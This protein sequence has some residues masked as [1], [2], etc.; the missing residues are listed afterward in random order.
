MARRWASG[1]E[2]GADE[3]AEDLAAFGAPPEIRDRC[4]ASEPPIETVGVLPEGMDAARLF[5]ALSTQWRFA[6]MD[7]V[8]T[9]IDYGA[10][11]PTAR[12][13]GIEA[14]PALFDL[15]RTMEA[16]ALAARRERRDR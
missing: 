3:T 1:G 2:T 7:G 5:L 13:A 16:E 11:E 10:V 15:V 6:G 4:E 9:G 14:T 8:P 12:L